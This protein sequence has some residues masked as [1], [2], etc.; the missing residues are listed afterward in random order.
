MTFSSSE[1]V[2]RRIS[3]NSSALERKWVVVSL[4]SFLQETKKREENNCLWS[5]KVLFALLGIVLPPFLVA[6]KELSPFLLPRTTQRRAYNIQLAR[7]F[8]VLRLS[9]VCAW[10]TETNHS[11]TKQY[12]MEFTPT[13]S[14]HQSA[15]DDSHSV[16]ECFAFCPRP[17]HSGQC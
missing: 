9:F 10:S 17:C 7:F 11:T 1:P 15:D 4:S 16:D 5:L 13:Q 6:R 2:R 14:L 3:S 12:A 8:L